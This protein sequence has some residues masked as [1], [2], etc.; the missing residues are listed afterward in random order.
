[1]E[2]RTS[3]WISTMLA[4]IA[5]IISIF[6]W[7]TSRRNT[8]AAERNALAAEK[9]AEAAIESNNHLRTK[10]EHDR[11]EEVMR[12]QAYRALYKKRLL[13]KVREIHNA[14][15]GKY[16]MNS[17]FSNEDVTIDRES[18]RHIPKDIIFSDDILIKY[19]SQEERAQIDQAWCS[20]R[21]LL[22][23]YGIDDQELAGMEFSSQVISDFHRLI[24][25]LER[26]I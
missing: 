10:M 1:M 12:F 5:I 22:K 23:K 26:S 6:S 20:L 14:V 9:S 8:L 11:E 7:W 24:V 15:L 25:M 19:F 2:L 21:Y 18:I 16:Q 13:Q 17:P 3:E 4:I